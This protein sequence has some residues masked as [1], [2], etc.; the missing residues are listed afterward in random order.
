[1]S[2]FSKSKSSDEN[3]PSEE[4]DEFILRLMG[5][6]AK[7]TALSTIIAAYSKEIKKGRVSAP[8]YKR[9]DGSDGPAVVWRDT[10]LEAM[11]ILWQYGLTGEIIILIAKPLEQSK[12]LESFIKE[13]PHLEFPHQPNGV[14][15][16]DIWQAIFQIYLYL[17]KI[18]DELGDL[19][20]TKG[21]K[22]KNISLTEMLQNHENEK[23]INIFSDFENQAEVLYKQWAN[24]SDWTADRPQT[25]F[26]ILFDDV[27]NKSKMIA[28]GAYFG[29]YYLD[30]IPDFKSILSNRLKEDGGTVKDINH[31][32]NVFDK[33]INALISAKDCD[34]LLG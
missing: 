20:S 7:L 23:K 27:T 34:E 22:P 10:R 31:A 28:L 17:G 1:M 19:V 18:S 12:L 16:H 2:W 3:I 9:K 14:P 26:D 32:L 21:R 30:S 33:N 13:K 11:A 24:Y 4:A 5:P 6:V 15:S 8:A 29:P 25:I